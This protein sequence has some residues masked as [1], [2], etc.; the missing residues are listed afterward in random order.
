MAAKSNKL[1]DKQKVSEVIT[2]EVQEK[3]TSSRSKWL[4]ILGILALTFIA[5]LPGFS[6][7][8]EFTNW[9]DLGYVVDQPL[10]K[11]SNPDSLKL[12]FEPTTQV[13][14]NDDVD[15][16]LQLFKCGIRHSTLFQNEFISSPFKH[17]FS[18]F[19]TL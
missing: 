7:E 11:T 2:R 18:F 12:L 4:I 10:V 5:Y 16:G 19:S 1:K 13:M 14:L 8:K 6:P 17:F 9:D 3:E 15:I